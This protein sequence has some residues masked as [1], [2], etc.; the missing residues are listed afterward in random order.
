[1]SFTD[2]G[3]KN[4]SGKTAPH[5]VGLDNYAKS[6]RATS[7]SRTSTSCGSSSS[8]SSGR[9]RTSSSTSSL[10]VAIALLL[11]VKGLK[12][13]RIYRAIYILPVIIPPIIVA[14]VWRNMFDQDNGAVNH[15]PQRAIG[16]LFKIPPDVFNI[17]WLGQVNDPISFIPLPL[18]YFALLA[19]NIWLGW[20]LNAVVATGAL[21]SIP[22]DLYEAA[23]M[24][25]A[26]PGSS[27]RS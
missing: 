21:Q 13:K 1:M 16:V 11:N 12:F 22:P 6:S 27:S 14:T 20:P 17:D 23:E 15:G 24:D 2:F 4:L 9:S 26:T 7:T 3:L 8:T 5:I 19:A 25:G 10:G 18:A